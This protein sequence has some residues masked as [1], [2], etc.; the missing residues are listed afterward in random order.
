MEQ[1]R[2][3]GKASA[4]VLLSG[5]LDSAVSLYWALSRGWEV[6][7]IEFEYYLRPQRERRACLSLRERAGIRDSIIVPLGFIREVSDLPDEIVLN[8][9]LHLSPEG[10]IPARNLLFYSLAAYYAE[11]GGRRYIVGGHNRSDSESFP[12]AGQDFF[13]YLNALFS[14]GMWS[15]SKI[16]TEIVLPLILLDKTQV[17]R[18]GDTLGVPFDLTWSCYHDGETPCGSCAS[19]LERDAAFAAAYNAAETQNPARQSS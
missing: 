4:L 7:T 16:G 17:L 3:E 14:L 8:S 18:L 13:S 6:A 1:A 19:C 2:L 5:G 10:Y 15:H 12:D 11:L 9:S